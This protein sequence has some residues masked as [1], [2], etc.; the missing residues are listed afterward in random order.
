MFKLSPIKD[1][2]THIEDVLTLQ[3]R[4]ENEHHL[5]E[6]LQKQTA[7]LGVAKSQ[8]LQLQSQ[9]VLQQMYCKAVRTQLVVK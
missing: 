5:L 3:L 4:T 1:V 6:A 8:V 7:K 2:K 9:V